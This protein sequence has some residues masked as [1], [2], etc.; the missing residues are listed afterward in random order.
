MFQT[1]IQKLPPK[2]KFAKSTLI[3][4]WADLSLAIEEFS[5]LR[6]R[7]GEL[8]FRLTSAFFKNYS[9]QKSALDRV[10]DDVKSREG[11]K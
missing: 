10:L 6:L 8:P 3:K 9:R 11:F 2:H 4:N 7:A 5:A 1:E